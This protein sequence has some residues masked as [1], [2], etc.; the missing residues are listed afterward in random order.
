MFGVR[1]ALL[2]ILKRLDFASSRL[3]D[4]ALAVRVA[5]MKEMH[6]KRVHSL[7]HLHFPRLKLDGRKRSKTATDNN[8]NGNSTAAQHEQLSVQ[9][10]AGDGTISRARSFTGESSDQFVLVDTI[11]I[12]ESVSHHS[13]LS[14]PHLMVS[15]SG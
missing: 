1:L 10:S 7:P 8:H 3:L 13:Q 12:D 11:S 6:F 2:D 15:A 9:M 4:D 14:F 5:K